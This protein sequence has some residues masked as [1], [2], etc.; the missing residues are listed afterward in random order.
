[1]VSSPNYSSLASHVRLVFVC[2]FSVVLNVYQGLRHTCTFVLVLSLVSGS[3]Q[4]ESTVSLVVSDPRLEGEGEAEEPGVK[5][6]GQEQSVLDLQHWFSVS[7]LCEPAL[8][9]TL[10]LDMFSL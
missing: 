8:G 10:F 4:V 5:A 1:M 7:M 9:E 2:T 6:C 3:P